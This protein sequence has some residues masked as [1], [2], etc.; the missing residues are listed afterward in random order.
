MKS[1]MRE[2]NLFTYG[3]DTPDALS[4][5]NNKLKKGAF[6]KDKTFIG[7][8]QKFECSISGINWER[9]KM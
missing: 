9:V 4:L 1:P 3:Y 8:D 7:N 5:N 6:K 2:P